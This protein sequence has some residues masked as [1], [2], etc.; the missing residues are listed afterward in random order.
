MSV[1]TGPSAA[2]MWGYAHAS[3]PVRYLIERRRW[4]EAMDLEPRP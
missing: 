1:S 4:A 2:P 3:I